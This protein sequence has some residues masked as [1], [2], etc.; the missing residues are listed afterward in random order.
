VAAIGDGYELMR[1]CRST[2]T[3]LDAQLEGIVVLNPAVF[4]GWLAHGEQ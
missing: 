3:L 1:S 4:L 2:V